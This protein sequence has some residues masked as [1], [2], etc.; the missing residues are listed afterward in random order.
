LRHSQLAAPRASSSPK[1][2][3]H[4][5]HAIGNQLRVIQETQQLGCLLMVRGKGSA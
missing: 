4:C 1:A 2:T 3:R 5:Y